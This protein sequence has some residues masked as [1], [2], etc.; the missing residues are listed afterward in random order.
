MMYQFNLG[1]VCVMNVSTW[2]HIAI[3][4]SRKHLSEKGFKRD[5]D[6]PVQQKA[7]H[8]AGHSSL[9]AGNVY[10]RLMSAAPGHVQS[11]QIA[12]RDVSRR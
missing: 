11:A 5:Y 1:F 3:A 10:A 7:D 2:R 12:Y 9:I 8:Q 4:I 6:D